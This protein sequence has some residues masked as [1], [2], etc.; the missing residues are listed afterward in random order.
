MVLP[1][2]IDGSALVA[3]GPGDQIRAGV[4]V[5]SDLGR[6]ACGEEAGCMERGSTDLDAAR[7]QH[8]PFLAEKV[9]ARAGCSAGKA[10]NHPMPGVGLALGVPA[11]GRL[12][13]S[14]PSG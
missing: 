7:F 8:S 2:R 1:F 14:N 11:P 6:H 12:L 4:H 3:L 10:F 5:G 13:L 9:L